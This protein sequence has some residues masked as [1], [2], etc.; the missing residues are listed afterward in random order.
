[1]L[2]KQG[3]KVRSESTDFRGLPEVARERKRELNNGFFWSIGL[4][5]GRVSSSG[6]Y[7]LI[8][9]EREIVVDSN[10]CHAQS[11]CFLLWVCQ[12]VRLCDGGFFGGQLSRGALVW[13][14]E[15]FQSRSNRFE[16]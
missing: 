8:H 2:G 1:M 16:R 7:V 11:S 9:I 12:G 6:G 5:Q 13:H 3:D 14:H 15:T 4:G 10:T